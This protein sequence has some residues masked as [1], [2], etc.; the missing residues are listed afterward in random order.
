MNVDEDR[1]PILDHTRQVNIAARELNTAKLPDEAKNW[2]NLHLRYT[3]GYGA[4]MTSAAQDA[5]KPLVWYLRDLNMTSPVGLNVKHPDLYYGE[6]QY[7]YAIVPNELKIGDIASSTPDPGISKVYHGEGGIGI[8][9]LFKKA[10]LAIFLQDEKIFFSTNINRDSKVKIRRKH[11]RPHRQTNAL[12]AIGQRPLSSRGCGSVLLDT[13][14]LHRVG[15]IPRLQAAG[16]YF[17][18]RQGQH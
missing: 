1:Y 6:G 16:I 8:D 3:H 18:A 17:C 13:R 12:F 15:Q 10:L 2:E 14:C 11:C 9:S 5:D 7:D 4:V